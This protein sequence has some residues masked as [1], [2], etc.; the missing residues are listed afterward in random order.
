MSNCMFLC[1]HTLLSSAFMYE[2]SLKQVV[3][4][5]VWSTF[6][7]IVCAFYSTSAAVEAPC[8]SMHL[9]VHLFGLVIV[10]ASQCFGDENKDVGK[11][12]NITFSMWNKCAICCHGNYSNVHLSILSHIFWN[13]S[14][15][16]THSWKEV[17]PRYR[18][19]FCLC[20]TWWK[21]CIYS[22]KHM[23]CSYERKVTWK[24]SAV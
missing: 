8:N 6:S 14:M 15:N 18:N 9:K 22:G 2:I 23:M 10:F 19:N 3:I 13:N 21:K 11:C 17:G 12:G 24:G 16:Y 4:L 1:F 20:L 7:R 5:C